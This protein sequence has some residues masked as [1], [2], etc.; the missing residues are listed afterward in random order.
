LVGWKRL[1]EGSGSD[2]SVFTVRL[3]AVEAAVPVGARR[4]DGWV[5]VV[6]R[7]RCGF[8]VVERE[9]PAVV[10]SWVLALAG[11]CLAVGVA[12]LARPVERAL[13]LPA[14]VERV[15]EEWL[16]WEPAGEEASSGEAGAVE[17]AAAVAAIPD[18]VESLTVD[19]VVAVPEAVPVEAMVE[20]ERVERVERVERPL[21]RRAASSGGVTRRA[22]DADAGGRA[23]AVAGGAGRSEGAGRGVGEGGAGGAAGAGRG[24]T[25][26]YF[27]TPPYPAEAR[28]RGQQGT[29]QL[30]IVFGADGRVARATVGRSSGFSDLD[31]AAAAWVRRH[32]RAAAGQV[33]S[34]RL[35]VHFKLR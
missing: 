33:G 17:S 3:D 2:M 7:W 31:R 34:F 14:V 12:G 25:A 9:R 32:W 13:G 26:G 21:V 27:P 28:R 4:A 8:R 23:G 6:D 30:Q 16:L 5:R 35:P 19:D 1:L 18:V 15:E 11:S 20:E 24:R 22:A 10:V 29:V